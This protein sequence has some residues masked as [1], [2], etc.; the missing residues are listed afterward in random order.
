MP[1]FLLCLKSDIYPSV[2]TSGGAFLVPNHDRNSV[3][4]ETPRP[5]YMQDWHSHR[6]IFS[7]KAGQ[8]SQ[9]WMDGMHFYEYFQVKVKRRW[10]LLELTH[11]LY[12]TRKRKVTLCSR[13]IQI[14]FPGKGFNLPTLPQLQTSCVFR[15]LTNLPTSFLWY[16][17]KMD[18]E[19]FLPDLYTPRLY[20]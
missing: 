5:W 8:D 1:G 12:A 10:I 3:E 2:A 6:H 7:W 16:S 14:F 4:N 18:G 17:S 13:K 11:Q 19:F 9:A 20:I 15:W